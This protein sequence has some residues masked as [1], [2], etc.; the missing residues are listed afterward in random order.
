MMFP[1]PMSDGGN[2]TTTPSDLAHPEN[3]PPKTTLKINGHRNRGGEGKC[4][5]ERRERPGE[6]SGLRPFP[7]EAIRQP[8]GHCRL[9]DDCHLHG[10]SRFVGGQRCAAPYRRQPIRLDRRGHVG[11]DQLPGFECHHAAGYGLDYAQDRAQTP[12]DAVDHSVYRRLHAVRHGH[13]Y[14]HADPGARFCRG[15]AAAGCSPWRSRFCWRVFR[16]PNMA[17]RWPFTARGSW[18][19]R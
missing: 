8:M 1:T 19:R 10:G 18:W 11:P 15:L 6:G 14:A 7:L 4:P 17:K 3:W 5:G 13:Q 2:T 12:A 16:P 9:G